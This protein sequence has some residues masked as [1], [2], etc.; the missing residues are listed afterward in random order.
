MKKPD[1]SCVIE[2]FAIDEDG[3]FPNSRLPVLLYKKVLDLPLIF[4]ATAARRLFRRNNWSNSWIY[5]IFQYHHYHSTSHEALAVVKGGT[6]IQLGGQNGRVLQISHGDVL[7]IPAG[8]AHRNLRKENQVQCVGAYPGGMEYDMNYGRA[9][10]R[11]RTDRNIGK[12]PHP[13][14]DPVF[15]ASGGVLKYW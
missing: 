11:P 14:K 6:A 8:V 5:G 4:G 3:V 15:G 7:I 2:Q 9:G 12:V 13:L 1:R 10:E